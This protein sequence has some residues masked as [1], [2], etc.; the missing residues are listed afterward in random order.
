MPARTFANPRTRV[1]RARRRKPTTSRFPDGQ[2]AKNT[3]TAHMPISS[4]TASGKS[5][6]PIRYNRSRG[7]S[8]PQ[9]AYTNSAMLS[10]AHAVESAERTPATVGT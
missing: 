7:H 9:S 8:A 4:I 10:T 3:A 5:Q 6:P 1:G 2:G